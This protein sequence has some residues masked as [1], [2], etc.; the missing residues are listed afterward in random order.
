MIIKK[1]IP[2]ATIIIV[3]VFLFG[4]TLLPPAGKI[5]YG[6]DLE[7]Q[8]YFW[9]GYLAQS[10]RGG[11]IPFWNPYT[12]S[13][14]PFL[15]HP[16][17]TAFYPATLLFLLFPLPFAFSLNFAL[18]FIIAGIGMYLLTRLYTK[19]IPAICSALAFVLGG[20]LSSRV[21]A[22]HVEILSTSV[23]IPW[24]IYAVKK[25]VISQNKKNLSIYIIILSLAILAGYQAILLFTGELIM[26]YFLFSF[27]FSHKIKRI[28]LIK[29]F[30]IIGLG[31][32]L[33]FGITAVQWIPVYEFISLSIRGKG[34]PY[35]FA[36]WGSFP[37]SALSLFWDPNNTSELMKFPYSFGGYV[38]PNFFEYYNGK[39]LISTLIGGIIVLCF[40]S[41]RLLIYKRKRIN[42]HTDF[43]IYILCGLIFFWISFGYFAPLNLH[44]LAYQN[45]GFYKN[46]R[47][48]SQHLI[49]IAVILPLL[50][51]MLLQWFGN[52]KVQIV[53]LLLLIVELFPYA[54]KF[55]VL[56]DIPEKKFDF[57]LI[58]TFD[59]QNDLFRI[60]PDYTVVSPVLDVLSMNAPLKYQLQST[61]G[62]D[63]MIVD[64]YHEFIDILN[65]S[66][67][68][69]LLTRNVE[70]AP[71][72]LQ[73]DFINFLNAKYIIT[74]KLDPTSLKN[75]NNY[76]KI[77]DTPLYYLYENENAAPRFFFVSRA[78]VFPDESEMKKAFIGRFD[79][80]LSEKVYVSKKE[81]EKIKTKMDTNCP[82]D[83]GS[84]ID[85]KLY[86]PNRIM[87][88]MDASCDGFVSSSEV[89][90]PGWQ[91]KSDGRSTPILKSNFSFRSIPVSKGIHTIEL[92]YTPVIYY[93]GLIV[94]VVAGGIILFIMRSK[95]SVFVN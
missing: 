75:K 62:Y 78:E 69:S 5:I 45:L 31:S 92:F 42:L 70:I 12:F 41:L 59:S 43:F 22:G 80:D 8:F 73:S 44:L 7:N 48:P 85:V 47:I 37:M 36:S 46:I 68:R 51:G 32:V 49:V 81:L 50:F 34:M 76:L 29:S 13:G 84:V 83:N 33:A 19:S 88:Q 21:Y 1:L 72:D 25:L 64:T 52:L 16:S 77:T 20:Y 24:I 38:L 79:I 4:S 67:D 82:Q 2:Y 53:F 94:T 10:L 95:K 57:R 11:V 54:K 23:W 61:S 90:Y 63:P 28:S 74:E 56:T 17:T 14:S 26:M 89:Y 27:L 65:K 60:L 71:P 3:T 66:S 58:K 35:P 93:I 15:A 6:G 86:S 18:H 40:K 87:L 30:I 39:I 55:Y 9:K 91:A